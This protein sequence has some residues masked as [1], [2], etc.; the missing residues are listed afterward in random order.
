MVAAHQFLQGFFGKRLGALGF[1]RVDLGQVLPQTLAHG[2]L[3]PGR[4]AEQVGEVAG[5]GFG[6]LVNR[7]NPGLGTLFGIAAAAGRTGLGGAGLL[8]GQHKGSDDKQE[9]IHGRKRE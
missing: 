7:V 6:L 2:G 5:E 8:H 1:Q 9:A 3:L 4:Q